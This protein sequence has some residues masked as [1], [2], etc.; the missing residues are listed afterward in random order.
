MVSITMNYLLLIYSPLFYRFKFTH[1][2]LENDET[3]T[4]TRHALQESDEK[5]FNK[6]FEDN[7]TCYHEFRDELLVLD[8]IIQ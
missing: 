5:A 3:V 8:S 6:E 2:G 1:K 4:L 7:N